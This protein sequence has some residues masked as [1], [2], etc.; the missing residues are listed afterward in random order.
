MAE[1]T[2]DVVQ[3]ISAVQRTGNRLERRVDLDDGPLIVL[4][5]L[6]PPAPRRSTVGRKELLARLAEENSAKLILVVAPAGWGKTSLLGEWCSACDTER[7]AWLSVDQGDND[8]VSFWAHVI[9]A[10]NKVSPEINADARQL[11]TA[12]GGKSANILLSHL[13]NDF[14]LMP[15]RVTLIVDDYDQIRN[16]DI[17]ECVEYLIE[18]MPPSLRLVLATRSG[19]ALPLAR[20]RARGE[21][22][23]IRIDDLRFTEAETAGLLNET[24]HLGLSSEDIRLLCQR[25]E[26]W[27]AG[28]YLAGLSLSGHERPDTPVSS[29]AGDD[30]QIVD[31]LV[32]EVLDVQP[33]HIRSFLLRTAVLDR[34]SA[35]LCDAVTGEGGSQ[36]ILEEIERTGLFVVPLDTSRRWYRYHTLFAETLRREL[37]RSEPRL[38]PLLHRRA[39]EWYR[40]EGS[41]AEAVGHAMLASD[42]ADARELIATRCISYFNEG[43]AGTAESWLR[44]LPPEMV[45]ED[46]RLCLANAWIASHLGRLD[47]VEPWLK[48]GDAATRQGALTDGP[49]SI[50][51]AVCSVRSHASHLLGDLAGAEAASRRAVELAAEGMGR[52]RAVALAALGASLCWQ[53]RDTESFEILKPVAEP[54]HAP[55]DNLARLWALGCLA[56]IALRQGEEGRCDG[57][58][59]RAADLMAQHGLGMY[60]EAAT[61]ILA[62][63]DLLESRGEL[64]A[65]EEAALSGLELAQRSQARLETALARLCLARIKLRAGS[66]AE[67]AALVSAAREIIAACAAPGIVTELAMSTARLAGQ[68][69]PAPRSGQRPDGRRADGLTGREAQVLR[70]LAAGKTNSEIAAELVVSVHTV[71]RHLQNAYR[72]LG[73]R[74]RGQAAAYIARDRAISA[75]LTKEG[76]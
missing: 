12:P 4:S 68:H 19:P 61:A 37:D 50:E 16:K 7:M 11:L 63:A 59:Q 20:L 43:L 3:P 71:E 55:V 2:P 5:K 57:Y 56:A 1:Q 52:C 45:A 30:R 67:A 44:S 42:L 53:G 14:E 24:L 6:H 28:L 64:R 76:G 51:S 22:T 32:A 29:F 74:N 58:L 23:E 73:V 60:R 26:G 18:H 40:Q 46:S 38:A 49:G 9:A 75:S 72:K 70:L 39:S 8:P 35:R 36:R 62:S 65:A 66:A 25:T 41:I 34:L 54:L 10:L 47:E 13:I 15:A 48:A 21:M 27:A 31:Y 69:A 33:D 17:H